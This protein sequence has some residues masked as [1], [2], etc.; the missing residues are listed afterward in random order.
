[1]C[2]HYLAQKIIMKRSIAWAN[3]KTRRSSF[4]FSP[5]LQDYFVFNVLILFN[6][7]GAKTFTN[8]FLNLGCYGPNY[9]TPTRCSAAWRFEPK[10]CLR[11]TRLAFF[12]P[13]TTLAQPS[14]LLLG[15]VVFYPVSQF[16]AAVTRVFYEPLLKNHTTFSCPN[17]D[18]NPCSNKT[19]P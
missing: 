4:K 17:M 11:K 7:D 2:S 15:L 6:A 10:P 3:W 16:Y 18:E 19:L 12:A 13:L 9:C 14:P 1:M 5:I 8:F